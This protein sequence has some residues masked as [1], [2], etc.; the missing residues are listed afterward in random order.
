[1][2]GA[3]GL[4]SHS[5]LYSTQNSTQPTGG[6][7]GSPIVMKTGLSNA[8]SACAA[9]RSPA[10]PWLPAASHA[11]AAKAASLPPARPPCL[12]RPPIVVAPSPFLGATFATNFLQR[13]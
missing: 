6:R 13:R 9:V 3:D 1:S 5:G 12:K 8:G 2:R 4:V 11:T 7:V 10:T